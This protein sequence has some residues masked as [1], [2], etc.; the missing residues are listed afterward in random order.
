MPALVNMNMLHATHPSQLQKRNH[1]GGGC[2]EDSRD[3]KDERVTRL[4]LVGHS[5]SCEVWELELPSVLRWKIGK[6]RELK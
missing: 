3:P 2:N 6:V 1:Q 4:S 5:R